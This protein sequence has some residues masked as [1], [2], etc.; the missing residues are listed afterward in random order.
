MTLAAATR[1]AAVAFWSSMAARST[2]TAEPAA[3]CRV[4]IA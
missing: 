4:A 3:A 1:E 2:V